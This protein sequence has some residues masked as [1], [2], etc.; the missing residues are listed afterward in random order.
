MMEAEPTSETLCSFNQK[1]AMKN[2]QD[3]CQFYVF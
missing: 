1:E 3:M 2:A